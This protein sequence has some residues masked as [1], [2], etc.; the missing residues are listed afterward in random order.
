MF[1]K[2]RVCVFERERETGIGSMSEREGEVIL[3]CDVK[4]LQQNGNEPIHFG[5]QK[6]METNGD[7]NV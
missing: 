3:V 7:P 1:V 4:V 2:K 6:V 5:R